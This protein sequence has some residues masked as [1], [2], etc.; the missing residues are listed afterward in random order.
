MIGLKLNNYEIVSVIGEGGMG[1]VYLARH[2]YTGRRA[3]IKTL[4]PERIRDPSAV[5]RFF[6]EARATNA[7]QHPNIIDIIDAGILSDGRTPGLL[8]ELLDGEPLSK[9][10]ARTHLLPIHEAVEIAYQAAAGLMAA[11]ARQIIHR[12]LKPENLF[13]VPDKTAPCKVRVKILDFGIAKL[14]GELG[15]LQVQ[16]L[17][18]S[19]VGT[20]HYMS[21][22]QCRGNSQVI[23]A[24]TDIYS[25]GVILYEMLCGQTPFVGEGLGDLLLQL[26]SQEPV[27]VRERAPEVPELLDRTVMRAL[28]KDPDDRFPTMLDFAR[29]MRHHDPKSAPTIGAGSHIHADTDQRAVASAVLT[30]D[31]APPRAQPAPVVVPAR[32]P[33]AQGA[34]LPAERASPPRPASPSEVPPAPLEAEPDWISN[35]FTTEQPVRLPRTMRRMLATTVD[36]ATSRRRRWT[37]VVAIL[38]LLVGVALA[39]AYF[40]GPPARRAPDPPA[41]SRTLPPQVRPPPAPPAPA[42]PPMKATMAQVTAP[43]VVALPPTKAESPVEAAPRAV[44]SPPSESGAKH[45]RKS[46]AAPESLGAGFDPT[47]T[48]PR[49]APPEPAAAP[50]PAMTNPERTTKPAME[51]RRNHL[52]DRDYPEND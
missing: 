22:E 46:A 45:R 19:V 5:T 42:V 50:L 29:A 9:R 10:L 39:L 23:D 12:D 28:A 33:V 17:P 7:I 47:V 43:P 24:R 3:A 30:P 44:P 48:K 40:L 32:M 18:G 49:A 25:L 41:A 8:M 4:R 31:R 11:H 35:P 51:K 38:A 36:I 52:L 13:L 34:A 16:T 27:S 26:R 15:D 1:T 2:S 37:V 6:N 21:P 14:R 20:P